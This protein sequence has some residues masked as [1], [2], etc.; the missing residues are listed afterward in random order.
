M[1]IDERK[2]I[3]FD[4]STEVVKQ[5]LTLSTAIVTITAI[6]ARFIF[7]NASNDSLTWLWFSWMSF[8]ASIVLGIMGLMS[9]SGNMEPKDINNDS[10]PPSIYNDGTRALVGGQALFFCLGILLVVIYGFCATS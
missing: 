5:I 1:D 8:I 7:I 10:P 3:A 4:L 2:K 6:A 9:L